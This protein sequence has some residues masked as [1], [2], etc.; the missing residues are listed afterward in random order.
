MARGDQIPMFRP[1]PATLLEAAQCELGYAEPLQSRTEG[2]RTPELA[3]EPPRVQRAIYE[4][5]HE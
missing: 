3:K 1:R 4:A 2:E 5:H